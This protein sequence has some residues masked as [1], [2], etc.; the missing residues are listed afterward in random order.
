METLKLAVA[1]VPTSISLCGSVVLFRTQRSV[2]VSLQLIGSGFLFI[3]VITHVCEALGTFDSMVCG[4]EHSIGH[5][6]DLGSAVLGVTL[7]STGYGDSLR[8][9]RSELAG[10]RHSAVTKPDLVKHRGRSPDP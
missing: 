2:W 3:V 1:L 10:S 8:W 9:T 6:L 5:Y 4:M 7:F